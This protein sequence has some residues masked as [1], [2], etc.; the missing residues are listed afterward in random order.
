MKVVCIDPRTSPLWQTLVVKT[1]S[2]VF[3]SPSWIQVLTDTYGWEASAY[4]IVDEAGEPCAGIPLCRITDMFGERIV[5]LPFSDYCDPLIR[6]A[7]SWRVLIEKLLPEQVPIKLRCLHNDVPL[8]DKRFSLVKQARWHR[9]DLRPD[10][11]ALWKTMHDSTHRA[12]RK[13][14]REGLTVRMAESEPDLRVFF[15]MHLKIRKYKYGLLAQPYSFLQNIWRHFVEPRHGFLMLAI[16]EDKI[17]AGDFFLE[18][19]DTLYYKFNAS[20]HDDLS[21]RPNDLLIWHGI[22]EGKKRGLTYLDFG[23]SDIDQEGLIRYK[24]KFGG[25]EKTISFLNHSPN[26]GLT[27]A[28][29]EMKELLGKLTARFTDHMVPD[30]ITEKAGEDLYRLFS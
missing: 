9:L 19:K 26:G 20:L 17:V 23:L 8:S 5:A 27:R 12:I 22:Q 28:Q 18:W 30:Q 14:E 16:H 6:D 13:S 25:E 24:R 29:K 2:S 15:E 1:E 11:E 7:E 21:H 10:L 4:V 3:H